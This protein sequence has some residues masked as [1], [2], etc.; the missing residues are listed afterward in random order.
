MAGTSQ[1]VERSKRLDTFRQC[2]HVFLACTAKDEDVFPL[3]RRR[4]KL[5]LVAYGMATA[6]FLF[7]RLPFVFPHF[8]HRY[9]LRLVKFTNNNV[10]TNSAKRT[11]HTRG[12]FAFY[13]RIEDLHVVCLVLI[14]ARSTPN[15]QN[16]ASGRN[17]SW[18]ILGGRK[19][20]NMFLPMPTHTSYLHIGYIKAALPCVFPVARSICRFSI[21]R[22]ILNSGRKE[23]V[24]RPQTSSPTFI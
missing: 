24:S 23:A 22:V 4:S 1:K 9:T 12:P 7:A 14:F 10:I 8:P 17:A 5:R 21:P 16:V 13:L 3:L 15:S 19:L 18:R 20:F 6:C 11:L 2:K